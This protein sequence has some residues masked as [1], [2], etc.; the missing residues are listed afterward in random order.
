MEPEF[1]HE[2]WAHNEIGFHESKPNALL[3]AH[4]NELKLKQGSRLFLPLCGKTLDIRWLLSKGYQVAGA[5]LS[6]TAVE[7][8]FDE[9]DLH[10]T[11]KTTNH[12]THYHATHLDLFVGDIFELSSD[13]LGP[14]DAVYDRAALVA[15][16]SSMRQK[17]SGHLRELTD[18]ADQLLVT[19]EYDQTRMDGPP[20]SVGR[21]EINRHYMNSHGVTLIDSKQ[22]PVGPRG[23]SN[24]TENIWLLKANIS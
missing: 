22:L 17:Y 10:P 23:V 19:F 6:R 15:L 7:Q 18:N 20:F 5:E 1:W 14:I 2:K 12:L 24:A 16:P 4:V 11:T 9:L 13:M 3:A 8:L 21:D